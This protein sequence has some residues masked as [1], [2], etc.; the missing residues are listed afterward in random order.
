[1]IS[2]RFTGRLWRL[3]VTRALGSSGSTGMQS[4]PY[5]YGYEAFADRPAGTLIEICKALGA[6]PP[7]AGH[8]KPSLAKLSDA[9][10]LEWIG[11]YKAD[12]I[13]AGRNADQSGSLSPKRPC[14]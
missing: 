7:E 9:V 10:S 11:R 6:E 13:K 4:A 8:V 2:T 12:L 3:S 1:M 5:G 14:P